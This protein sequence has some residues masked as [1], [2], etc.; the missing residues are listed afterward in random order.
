M[1]LLTPLGLLGLIG[2][3]IWLIIYIIKPNYQQK[4]IS[5]TFVWKLSLKY[6]KKKI[7]I[8]KLRNLLLILCQLLI[9]TAG[10]LILAQPNEILKTPVKAP[11]VIAIIDASASMRTQLDGENR[12]ER[13]V[14]GAMELSEDTLSK[15]GYVSVIL[16]GTKS[17]FLAQRVTF[18]NRELVEDVLEPLIE[19]DACSYGESDVEG[20]IDLCESVLAE[21][22]DAKIYFYTDTT[23]EYVPERI[24]VVDVTDEEEWNASILEANAELNDNYYTFTVDVAC[25]GMSRDIEVRLEVQNA[26][27]MDSNDV[28]QTIV[29]STAVFCEDSETMRVVFINTDF[30]QEKE[31]ELKNVVYFLIDLQDRIYSYQSV[32]ITLSEDDSFPE[33][34]GFNI[35]N[36]QKEVLKFQYAS[37]LPNPFFTTALSVLKNTFADRWDIQ[38]TEIKKGGE[39]ATEGFDFYL[40]EHQ[41]PE[42]MPKDGVVFLAN[43]NYSYGSAPAGSG[44]QLKDYIIE[45]DLGGVYLVGETETHPI[46]Q[47]LPISTLMISSLSALSYD[48]VYEVL[49]TCGNEPALLV[50]NEADMKAV[51]MPFSV[52]YSDLAITAGLPTLV[53]NIFQYFFP[54]TIESTDGKNSVAAVE[55]YESVKLNARGQEL[56]VSRGSET[57]Y[58]FNEF[59]ATLQLDLPGT[60]VLTQTTFSGK[61][62]SENIYVK[63]PAAESDIFKKGEALRDPSVQQ[64]E[65]D[66]FKDLMLYFAIALV[67]ILFIEWWLQSRD[68]M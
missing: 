12:F 57:L 59:P 3:L 23:Y 48:P 9:I 18:I 4:M 65:I 5:S 33:D 1:M 38:I 19:E 68:S 62:I 50:A 39:Y 27:A 56:Y 35:Y 25:Y 58:T 61:N 30:Y 7:P 47:H 44:I 55:V 53:Y 34:N 43:P 20:A 60:Y 52:H 42:K 14:D 66:Y 49:A 17:S 64:E 45:Y 29:F 51:V 10:A 2:L 54:S 36:G 63:I 13:A 26:N 11:E 6:K 67:A 8:S 22:P 37:A 16:A 32:H 41:M 24:T 40:F 28:G 46:M 21:N 15:N 31:N